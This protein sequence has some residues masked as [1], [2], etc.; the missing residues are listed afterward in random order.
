MIEWLILIGILAVLLISKN[1][2]LRDPVFWLA[3]IMDSLDW[4]ISLVVFPFNNALAISMHDFI[5]L[6][7]TFVFVRFV[8]NVGYFALTESLFDAFPAMPVITGYFPVYT[9]IYLVSKSG[10]KKVN[11]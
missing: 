5:Q 6:A 3:V 10:S 11:G 7:F 9:I 8:G 1:K 4:F 2:M